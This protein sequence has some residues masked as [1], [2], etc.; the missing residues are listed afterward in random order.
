MTGY[1]QFLE[2]SRCESVRTL[3]TKSKVGFSFSKTVDEVLY[4]MNMKSEMNPL[5]ASTQ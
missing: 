5:W 4:Y 3:P 2:K 1:S